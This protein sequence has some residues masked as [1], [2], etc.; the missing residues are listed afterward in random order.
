MA[1]FLLKL[2]QLLEPRLPCV[3]LPRRVPSEAQLLQLL[4]LVGITA[5]PFLLATT[6]LIIYPLPQPSRVT[7]RDVTVTVLLFERLQLLKSR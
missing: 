2:L 7:L 4:G 5:L 1:V 6:T 3:R